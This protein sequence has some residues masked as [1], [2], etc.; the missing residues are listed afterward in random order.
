MARS[1]SKQRKPPRPPS[2]PRPVPAAR[3][4][5]GPAASPKAS[6]WALLG[7]LVAAIAVLAGIVTFAG[8]DT[9]EGGPVELAHVHGL[10]VD[11]GSGVLYAGSHYGLIRLP[12]QGEPTRVADRVQDFMG[13]TVVGPGHFLA[14]GHPGEGQDGPANVG[15]IESTDGGRS[16]HELSLGGQADFHVLEARHGLIFGSN[17]GQLMVSADGRSWDDRASLPMADLAISPEDSQTLLAT[18]QQGL[19]RST[20]GGRSFGLVE[21]AP[22]LQLITWTDA[23][24]VLGVT[25]DGAVHASTDGGTRWQQRGSVDGTAEALAAVGDEVHVATADGIVSSTDGG[26]AFQIRY[27]TD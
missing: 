16:W 1:P 12:E 10:G 25:P 22:L 6:R 18:T 4:A 14:S 2:R 3:Q 11:P 9:G 27:A 5:R 17:A 23:G 8:R 21:S 7:G 19:A 26:H 13:F 24:T 15:L 20:D